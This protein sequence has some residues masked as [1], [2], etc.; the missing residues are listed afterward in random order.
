[1][2]FFDDLVAKGTALAQAQAARVNAATA[3]DAAAPDFADQRLQLYPNADPYAGQGGHGAPG[4]GRYYGTVADARNAVM[5]MAGARDGRYGQLA[6]Q[7]YKVGALYDMRYASN[8][9]SVV[10]A[11]D[12]AMQM[13][14]A[15]GKANTMS[16][17]EWLAGAAN[18]SK[19][20][21]DG[22]GSG[23]G[24]GSGYGPFTNS[25]VDFTNEMNARELVD[26]ALNQWLG[27]DAKPHERAK[28]Y[29][30]LNKAEAANP[31][32]T[33]GVTSKGGTSSARSGG[34][35]PGIMA[36]DFAKSRD[37]FAETQAST[38]ILDWI[39]ESIMGKTVDR[40]V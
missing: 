1:M 21:P 19:R 35:N 16:Y 5:G 18:K 24:S 40:M 34:V 10:S 2:G 27:R 23:G 32:V 30:Q 12:T 28:F 37:D 26:N 20:D 14:M 3:A 6:Q 22:S 8:V 33:T 11:N 15:S 7:L 13:Y 25:S 39:E 36:E 4:A 17:A 9:N 31:L 29:S 38:T